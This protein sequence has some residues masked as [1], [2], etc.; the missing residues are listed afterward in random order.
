M[1][2]RDVSVGG[3]GGTDVSYTEYSDKSKL[4]IERESLR[5]KMN[6]G[7]HDTTG[8]ASR[9]SEIEEKLKDYK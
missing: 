9:M 8:F 1:Q 4:V 5:D 2:G 6:I 7:Q 3:A